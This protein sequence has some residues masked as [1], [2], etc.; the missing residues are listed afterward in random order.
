MGSYIQLLS[1]IG[2]RYI[3]SIPKMSSK[4]I[5]TK[6]GIQINLFASLNDLLDGTSF[7]QDREAQGHLESLGGAF[8]EISKTDE[9]QVLLCSMEGLATRI[10][11]EVSFKDAVKVCFRLAKK[12][13]S[14]P[15][16]Q[17][18]MFIGMFGL[19]VA[20]IAH[21]GTISLVGAGFGQAV[22]SMG[23]F[24]I[25]SALMPL[26]HGVKQSVRLFMNGEEN[27]VDQ[28]R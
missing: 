27:F 13:T 2:L 12:I 23:M 26:S 17:F 1:N 4:T 21:F 6:S 15:W 10:K 25:S 9:G 28:K 11:T 16:V 20:L 7:Q 18:G 24:I 8:H 5:K 22:R 19:L 14:N 3:Q